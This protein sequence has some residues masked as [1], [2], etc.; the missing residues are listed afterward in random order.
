M[1]K[2]YKQRIDTLSFILNNRLNKKAIILFKNT[3]RE[4]KTEHKTTLSTYFLNRL[5]Q[6]NNSTKKAEI[7][8][9]VLSRVEVKSNFLNSYYK[10]FDSYGNTIKAKKRLKFITA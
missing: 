8:R 7:I 1:T 2:N 6:T 5:I 4:L 9:R 10:E 3:L